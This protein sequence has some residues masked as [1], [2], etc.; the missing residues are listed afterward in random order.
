MD[1]PAPTKKY[2]LQKAA[3]KSVKALSKRVSAAASS[4]HACSRL[5]P[6]DQPAPT[7]EYPLLGKAATGRAQDWFLWT[8]LHS[9]LDWFEGTSLH[10]PKQTPLQI[11]DKCVL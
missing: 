1:Q 10:S 6:M 9:A 5:V 8:S 3:T 4:H 2:P 7:K 11:L